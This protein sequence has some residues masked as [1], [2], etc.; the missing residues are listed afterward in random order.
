MHAVLI[1]G[2]Y[3]PSPCLAFLPG[4]PSGLLLAPAGTGRPSTGCMRHAVHHAPMMQQQT[5]PEAGAAAPQ[6]HAGR[7]GLAGLGNPAPYD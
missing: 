5:L 7:A 6:A 4:L 2:G 1:A 3:A